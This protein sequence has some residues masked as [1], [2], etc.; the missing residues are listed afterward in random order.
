MQQT[1]GRASANQ[2]DIMTDVGKVSQMTQAASMSVAK[3]VF[4]WSK[5][6]TDGLATLLQDME[7]KQG[8]TQQRAAKIREG[9]ERCKSVA[10]ADLREIVAAAQ[11]HSG[12]IEQDTRR[13]EFWP[14]SASSQL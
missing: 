6:A 12:V 1:L 11:Q 13:G 14:I 8:L 2:K 7:D 4:E 10:A 9:S 3:T 5:S